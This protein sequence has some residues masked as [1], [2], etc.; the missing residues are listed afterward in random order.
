VVPGESHRPGRTTVFPALFLDSDQET[1]MEP[2]RRLIVDVLKPYEPT[3]VELA[4]EVAAC[5]GVDGVNLSLIE[6]DNKVQ[7]VKLT[8]EGPDVDFEAVTERVEALSGSVHSVDQVVCGD[9]VVEERGTPQDR[10]EI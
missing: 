6:T 8:V 4:R 10:H 5:P 7:N 1:D 2:I 9:R 3:A